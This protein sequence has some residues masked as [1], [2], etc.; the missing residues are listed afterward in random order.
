MPSMEQQSV[1]ELTAAMKRG[2][3][4]A[5]R[6]F[7]RLY[8]DR[9]FRYQIVLH[10]GNEDR[11]ADVLQQ[12]MLRVVRHIRR[13]NDDGVFWS[14]LT[15]LS[16]CAAADEG[17][18]RSRRLVWVEQW[19]HSMEMRQGGGE[20]LELQLSHLEHCLAALSKE[21]RQLV[22]G[23]YFERKSYV[24]LAEQF[25]I[26]AKAIESRLAR[27]REKLRTAMVNMEGVIS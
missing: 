18:R 4:T 26:S 6:S 3:E 8:F 25:G 14:W 5:W 23:K 24:D 22:E 17:R 12:T 7:H 10:R 19:A 11:A 20:H 15:C 16:R 27:L 1:A 13:F 2:D 21:E 9:L